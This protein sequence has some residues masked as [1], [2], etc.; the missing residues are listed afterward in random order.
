MDEIKNI[1]ERINKKGEIFDLDDEKYLLSVMFL[2]SLLILTS[3]L[4][5]NQ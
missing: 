2:D 3:Q 4:S 5:V 1:V